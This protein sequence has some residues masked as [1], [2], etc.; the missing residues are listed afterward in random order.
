MKHALS[1]LVDEKFFED[2]SQKYSSKA[3]EE[4]RRLKL[5]SKYITL[6][7][8]KLHEVNPEVG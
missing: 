2:T 7:H 4:C 6:F 5:D 3:F 1:Y 8:N